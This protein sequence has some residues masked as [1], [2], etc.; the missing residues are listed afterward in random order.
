MHCDPRW[1]SPDPHL[2]A[3]ALEVHAD[4]LDGARLHALIDSPFAAVRLAAVR[5][6]D[7]AEPELRLPIGEIARFDPDAAVRAAAVDYLVTYGRISVPTIEGQLDSDEESVR[8]A[9]VHALLQIDYAAAYQRFGV[10]L[11][12]SAT[13]ASVEVAR[14]L[15][16]AASEDSRREIG[17]AIAHLQG[18]LRSP[19][20]RLRA[21]VASALDSLPEGWSDL[22]FV[23]R[24]LSSE[25]IDSIRLPL[26]TL[27]LSHPA[28]A[29][30][31]TRSL[32][33][34]DGGWSD[35]RGAGGARAGKAWPRCGDGASEGG[36][37][38]WQRRRPRD[39]SASARPRAE[40][41]TRRAQGAVGR[42]GECSAR[43]CSRDR[44]GDELSIRVA[45]S[46][47]IL[48]LWCGCE[49]AE[50]TQARALNEGLMA[51]RVDQPAAERVARLQALKALRLDVDELSEI[52]EQCVDAHEALLSAES[53]QALAQ[54][55]L[56]ELQAR[57]DRGEAF[58]ASRQRAGLGAIERSGQA[59][60][61]AKQI[62]SLC[63]RGMRRLA[64]RFER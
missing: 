42:A 37:R 38:R 40:T 27:L 41:R 51:L 22:R 11:E 31:G 25:R 17:V 43:G 60:A 18:A 30:S 16:L 50:R 3:A 45:T 29:R 26:A 23:V 56:A 28:Y 32:V 46:I 1:H 54:R 12:S 53:E 24:H 63:Q 13:P 55:V 15:L 58:D 2:L 48:S 7:D 10:W 6:L 36:S 9:A 5:R 39:R 34:P 61:R 52:R 44:R 49:D 57:Q 62:F 47:A 8:T 19:D 4:S 64:L 35:G 33:A 20:I 14:A 59:V 21:R